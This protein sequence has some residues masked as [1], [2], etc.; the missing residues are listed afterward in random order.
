MRWSSQN[1]NQ[2]FG[3][4]LPFT[5]HSQTKDAK[6]RIQMFTTDLQ[7]CQTP[8][9]RRQSAYTAAAALKAC[10]EAATQPPV[11]LHLELPILCICATSVAYLHIIATKFQ[12]ISSRVCLT[13]GRIQ[14]HAKRH[15]LRFC[16]HLLVTLA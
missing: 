7:G 12:I 9:S 11:D 10:C 8:D 13:N 3:L 1:A 5:R 6:R 14:S 4:F 15:T 2:K 16:W